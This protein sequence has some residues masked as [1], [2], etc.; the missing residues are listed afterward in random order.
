[1]NSVLWIIDKLLIVAYPRFPD[2]PSSLS[3]PWQHKIFERRS[4]LG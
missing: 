2:D 1:M 4:V 3:S